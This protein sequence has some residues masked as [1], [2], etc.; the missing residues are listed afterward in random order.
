MF[1]FGFVAVSF[2][3]FF[4]LLLSG[5]KHINSHH[6]PTGEISAQYAIMKANPSTHPPLTPKCSQELK[7]NK[8][9]SLHSSI[10]TPT[11]ASRWPCIE[12]NAIECIESSCMVT[13]T[14]L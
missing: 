11:L 12:K 7:L 4:F 3:F 13:Y 14:T 2:G 8:T 6:E 1:W 5:R 10:Y 9:A